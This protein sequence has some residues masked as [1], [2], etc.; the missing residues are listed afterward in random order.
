[1]ARRCEINADPVFRPVL[2]GRAR[3]ERTAHN[4]TA[5]RRSQRRRSCDGWIGRGLDI[6]V[7][8]LERLLKL[9]FHI[10]R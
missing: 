10:V 7:S 1:V 3:A 6:I 8:Q 4:R 9:V 2:K 5:R